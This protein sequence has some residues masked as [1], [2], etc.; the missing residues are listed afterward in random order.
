MSLKK[1]PFLWYDKLSEDAELSHFRPVQVKVLSFKTHKFEI[2]GD[3]IN[4]L[5]CLLYFVSKYSAQF[6][7]LNATAGFK[8]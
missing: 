3:W 8:V 4:C 1:V 5:L 7:E 6:I 2:N